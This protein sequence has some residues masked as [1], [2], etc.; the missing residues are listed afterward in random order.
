[1]EHDNSSSTA[2]FANEKRR[3]L[4]EIAILH[5]VLLGLR[6]L[7]IRPFGFRTFL[8]G[9]G[10]DNIFSLLLVASVVAAL[11]INVRYSCWDQPF[12]ESLLDP[13]YP[14]C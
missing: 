9:L 12:S 8:N 3:L 6:I 7:A 11:Q 14:S 5:S 1:M 4:R 10:H 2:R 13:K